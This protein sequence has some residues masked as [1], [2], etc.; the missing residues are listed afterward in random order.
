MPPALR[1]EAALFWL[2]GGVC[3]QNPAHSFWLASQPLPLCARD[4]GLFGMF[5]LATLALS[6]APRP[7]WQPWWLLGVL[8]LVLDGLN[9]FGSDAFGVA[10]YAPDNALRLASGCLAGMSL[11]MLLAPLTP[12]TPAMALTASFAFTAALSPVIAISLVGSAGIVVVLATANQLL[13]QPPRLAY[14]LA[15]PELTALALVSHGVSGLL[16]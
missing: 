5:L 10:L 14:A 15:L 3:S 12:R 9:S 2:D 6:F 11:A 7:G 4:L 8:P 13:R 1:L 16:R